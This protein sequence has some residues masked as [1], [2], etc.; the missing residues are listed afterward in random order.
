MNRKLLIITGK[1][2]RSRVYDDPYRSTKM[3][4]LRYSVPEY[5]KNRIAFYKTRK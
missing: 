5:I 2:L 3:N 1:G 4:V